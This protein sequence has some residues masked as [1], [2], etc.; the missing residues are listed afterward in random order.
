MGVL[1]SVLLLPMSSFIP[2][3]FMSLGYVLLE[4]TPFLEKNK[5]DAFSFTKE[6][7]HRLTSQDG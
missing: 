7:V 4:M 2:F 5:A 1:Q 3:D 6:E